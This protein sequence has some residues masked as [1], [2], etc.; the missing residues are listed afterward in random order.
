MWI[1]DDFEIT[2]QEG[3]RGE[4]MVVVKCQRLRED[5]TSEEIEIEMPTAVFHRLVR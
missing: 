1:F 3:K 4:K 2:L 5:R